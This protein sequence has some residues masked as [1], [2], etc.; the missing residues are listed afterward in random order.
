LSALNM[1]RERPWLG[2]G[3]GT[4]QDAYPRFALFDVERVVNFAH[5]DWLQWAAEGGMAAA[6]AMLVWAG[7]LAR[8]AVREPWALGVIFVLLHALVDYPMQRPGMAGW[9]FAMAGALAAAT[10]RT[11]PQAARRS[12][13]VSCSGTSSRVGSILSHSSALTAVRTAIGMSGAS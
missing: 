3:L 2:W 7:W 8:R 11:G 6:A 1:I 13:A 9:V 5:N 12:P 4:F 10:P